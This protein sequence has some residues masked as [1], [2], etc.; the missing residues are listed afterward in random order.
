MSLATIFLSL[1]FYYEKAKFKYNEEQLKRKFLQNAILKKLAGRI[2][3]T[4]DAKEII[5]VI[6]GS[7][8]QL[9]PYTTVSYL[10]FDR[11]NNKII[12]KID[13]KELVNQKF[14]EDV[15]GKMQAAFAA[16]VGKEF[17]EVGIEEKI[18]GIIPDNTPAAAL[19]SF[20]NLPLVIGGKFAGLINVASTQAGLYGDKET[21]VLYEIADLASTAVYKLS[22][23]IEDEEKKNNAIVAS[24]PIGLVFI[25]QENRVTIVNSQAKEILE[26][27]TIKH[28]RLAD[29]VM[30]TKQS[31]DL[32]EALQNSLSKNESTSIKDV[33]FKTGFYEIV[34][35]PVLYRDRH[36]LGAIVI[37]RNTNAEKELARSRDEFMALTVH[38]LRAPLVA[39]QW[40]IE[41]LLEDLPAKKTLIE[42]LSLIYETIRKILAL[43]DDLLS[44]AK[45][46]AGKFEIL[47]QK[48][49]FP[50]IIK[51]QVA[52]FEAQAKQKNI[53]LAS[54]IDPN[55]PEFSFD[56][57]RIQQL[58]SNLISNALK[59]TQEGS[60]TIRADFDAIKKVVL[61]SVIDTGSGI[62]PE[63]QA[64]LFKK[65]ASFAQPGGAKKSTGLGLIIAKSII[66]AH[67]GRIW[68][69]SVENKGSTFFFELPVKG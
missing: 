20:F 3:Y 36:K 27:E 69:E 46:E 60:I 4:F 30:K 61:V 24:L 45:I 39:S 42:K 44:V 6:S 19:R 67:N 63:M 49:N 64:K 31:F 33:E 22:Q 37:L 13:V 28:V 65:F 8:S 1:R 35:S 12:L 41:T 55:I 11:D 50:K 38:D 14:L 47:P 52:L 57:R 26:L 5:E 54:Y 9:V 17:K 16:I 68:V 59:F 66:E 29:L 23:L 32:T 10:L 43:I 18:V 40:T 7:L 56:G 21:E 62:S 58:M 51:E 25:D 15:K 53:L 48:N 34:V 2:G